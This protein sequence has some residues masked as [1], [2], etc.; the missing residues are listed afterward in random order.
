VLQANSS[1]TALYAAKENLV[2]LSTLECL[3]FVE[4]NNGGFGCILICN[5]DLLSVFKLMVELVQVF[6]VR[7]RWWDRVP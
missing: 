2:N 1:Q 3:D 5:L 4:G 7:G 6:S